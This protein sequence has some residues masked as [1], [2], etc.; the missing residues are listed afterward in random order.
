LLNRIVTHDDFDG[1]VSAAI[2]A[3]ALKINNFFFTGPRSITESRVRTD[4]KDVVCDLPFPADCG[5]W[6]DHHPGN[7]EELQYRKIDPDSIPG[8]FSLEPSCARI[9]FD[10]FTE[11][12]GLPSHFTEMTREADIIDSFNYTSIA[13]WQQETPGKIIDT[14]I[15]SRSDVKSDRLIFLTDLTRAL[16]KDSLETVAAFGWVES[17][18]Q[19]VKSME[20]AALEQIRKDSIFIDSDPHREI[21]ILDRTHHKRQDPINK[22]LAY[23]AF[24]EALAVIEFKNHFNRGVKTNNLAFSMSLSLNLAKEEHSKDVGEIMRLLNM[25]D[26]HAGA[27]A[28]RVSCAS[29][30][31]M[32]KTKDKIIADIFNYWKKQK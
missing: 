15:R 25:G 28:G 2:S 14:A 18:Y 23:I 12:D 30:P 29:K 8:K 5:M 32:L 22:N 20:A 19:S 7:L 11:I 9:V 24:P 6:F 16:A 1:L 3:R 17:R 26:G 10:Y 21:V 13:D 4:S 31:E 27:A